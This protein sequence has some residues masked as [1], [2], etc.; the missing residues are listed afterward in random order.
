MQI[1]LHNYTDYEL[2]LQYDFFFNLLI[3][4]LYIEDQKQLEPVF[5][6]LVL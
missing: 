3:I 2:L 6:G 5:A 1:K 4:N